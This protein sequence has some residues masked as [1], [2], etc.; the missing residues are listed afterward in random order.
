VIKLLQ[1][2]VTYILLDGGLKM[3]KTQKNVKM[4]KKLLNAK[5]DKKFSLSFKAI[6]VGYIFVVLLAFANIF[7]LAKSG[8]ISIFSSPSRIV[9][10]G[11]IVFAV[12]LNFCL[13]RVVAKSLSTALTQPIA[14]LQTAV[15]K[16][17]D[18]DFDIDIQYQS[19]DEL[20]TLAGEL[21]DLCEKVHAIISDTG[22]IL[23][24]MADGKFNIVSNAS[25]CYVG[26]FQKLLFG[27]DQLNQQ[28]DGTLRKIRL[29]SEQVMVGSE[30]LAETA[31]QLAE[32]SNDQ[33]S[34][35]EQLAANVANVTNISEES[36]VNAENAATSA[37]DAAESARQSREEVVQ[38]TEAME[39]ITNT[40]QEIVEII[41]AIE[42]IAAQTNLLSLNASIEA[43][44]AGEAG[45]GFAVVADQIGKLA[46]DSAQSAVTTKDLISKCIEEIEVGNSIVSN[47]M[48][49]FNSVLENME[50]FAGMAAG[51]AE[52]S[53]TQVNMLKEVEIGIEKITEVVQNNSVTAEETSAVSQELSAQ[54]TNL[55]EMVEH[56]V[57]REL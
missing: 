22:N 36:A 34:A 17:K 26:D 35:V 46:S 42:D 5:M 2:Y 28:L 27:L 4:N 53:K 44:R 55:E 6:Y 11:L 48:G 32:G 15:E 7:M 45:R 3:S 29:S 13:I 39:R 57:L 51:A 8:K 16:M 47:T 50:T 49:A 43:A 41:A 38:L 52:A 30:Q 31:Q 37:G 40:S 18:G 9:G 10:L 1:L 25:E 14:E 19:K 20:G 54:A 24:E 12:V 33:A 56:F 21:R 23:G